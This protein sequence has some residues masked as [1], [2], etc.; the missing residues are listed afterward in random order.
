MRLCFDATRFGTGL[1]EAVDL[2][3]EKNLTACEFA[4]DGFDLSA[5]GAKSLSKP[6]KEYLAELA[7]AAQSK[8]VEIACL[9]LRKVLK[10]SDEESRKDFKG[11]IDKLSKVAIALSCKRLI[12]H[13]EAEGHDNWIAQVEKTLNP[14][15]ASLKKNEIRL[16][17]SLSTPDS[18][19]G[20]S[21]SKWRPI[22]PQEWRDLLAGVP[23]LA[24]S[25]SVA[26][27]AWQGIDYLKML[28]SLVPAIEHVEAQDVQ[29]NRQIIS[30]NGYFGPLFWRYM[31]VGKGQVDWG[32]FVEALKLYEYKGDL[33]IHFND[34]FASENEQ[35]LMEALESSLKVLAPLLK[36]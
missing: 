6:E 10:V 17:L 18:M 5:K 24:L 21:L 2:A 14:I 25:Y 8:G 13:L 30:E 23:D 35:G 12:F 4:F 7:K 22:E 26:D 20:K 31:T 15:I 1:Q 27:S 33:S 9:R 36:Y 32:Q 19:Q 28:P 29:V 16:L 3:V 34:E 11:Q